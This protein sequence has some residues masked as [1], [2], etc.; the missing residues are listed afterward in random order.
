M[1]QDYYLKTSLQITSLDIAF[2][3]AG[4]SGKRMC[5]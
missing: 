4:N 1:K 2:I 5:C 3:T